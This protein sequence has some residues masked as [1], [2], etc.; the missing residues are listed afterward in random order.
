[1]GDHLDSHILWRIAAQLEESSIPYQVN[2]SLWNPIDHV[3][4]HEH[5]DRV[6][7]VFLS[8]GR[9]LVMGLGCEGGV[10]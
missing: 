4:L 8:A 5:I 9:T 1:M 2:L 7:M 6:G 10:G 3:K